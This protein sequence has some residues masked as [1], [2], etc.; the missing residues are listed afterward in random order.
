MPGPGSQ[1]IGREEI[2]EVLDV[3]ESGSLFRYGNLEDPR[4]KHKVYTFEREFAEACGVRHAL[5]VS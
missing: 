5:G 3:L 4:F 2:A 1:R